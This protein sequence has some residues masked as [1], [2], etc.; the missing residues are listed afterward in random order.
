MSLLNVNLN[1]SQPSD[2]DA[3]RSKKSSQISSDPSSLASNDASIAK[4]SHE[5]SVSITK[6][7]GQPSI[8][9]EN[10]D[11]EEAHN[12]SIT[13][14]I[15]AAFP[16]EDVKEIVQESSTNKPRATEGPKPQN[17]YRFEYQLMPDDPE[18]IQA[19]L[20][21]YKIAAKLFPEKS[22][23][24]I[25]KSW[26]HDDQIWIIWSQTHELQLTKSRLLKLFEHEIVLKIWDSR[27]FCSARTKFDKPKPFKFAKTGEYVFFEH[28]FLALNFSSHTKWN[29]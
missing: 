11:S 8:F 3:T 21:T 12:V 9:S 20:V 23:P 19:D 5:L 24:R 13:V 6:Q 18:P 28:D 1:N 14:T 25:I 7:S 16:A 17:F 26:E 27:D 10:Q 22:E 29:N 15:C 4:E 2:S